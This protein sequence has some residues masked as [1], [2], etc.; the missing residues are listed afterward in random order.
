MAEQDA[1]DEAMAV[2]PIPTE[3]FELVSM[4]MRFMELLVERD[5]E[6]VLGDV[7]P[8]EQVSLIMSD[9]LGN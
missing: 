5:L 1:P 6:A 9:L 8:P 7:L 4:S 3:R 2:S